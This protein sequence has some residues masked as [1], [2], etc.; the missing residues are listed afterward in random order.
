V[1]SFQPASMTF[2]IVI[3]AATTFAVLGIAMTY[4]WRAPSRRRRRE[5][6]GSRRVR[7]L[8]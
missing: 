4:W 1:L 8:P 5:P 7:G 3:S 6:S 2:G